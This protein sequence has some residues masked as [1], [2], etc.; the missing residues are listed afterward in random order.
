MRIEW[1]DGLPDDPL[2]GAQVEQIRTSGKATS[3]VRSAVR[4]LDEI[5]GEQLEKELDEIQ[6]DEGGGVGDAGAGGGGPRITL[7]SGIEGEK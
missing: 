4:R 6:E 2:E 7:P 5:D 1:K 3:S